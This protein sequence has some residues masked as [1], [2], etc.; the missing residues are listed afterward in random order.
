MASINLI[1]QSTKSPAVIYIRLR[2]GRNIDLKAKTNYHIDPLNW[3]QSEQRP[4]KKVRKDIDFANLDTDLKDLK[5]GLLKEYNNSK[6]VKIID[7]QWIN[8]YIN[9]PKEAEI[10]SNKLIDYIDIFI[11][12]RKQDVKASTITKCNGIK[13]LL[14]RYQEYT[15]TVLHIRDIDVKFKMD[16]EKYCL[17][18][19][20]APNTIARNIRFIKTFCRHAKSNGVETNYQLDNIK[21]KYHKVD[22]IYLT[23][24]EISKIVNIPIKDLSEGIENARDWL[25][26]SCYCGQRV[27]DFLRFDKSMIRYE[28]NKQGVLTPLI[29]FTQMKTDKLM[30]IPLSPKVIEIMKKYDG[31]FPK[32]IS[33]QKYNIH[34]KKVCEIAKINE[35]II[36]TKFDHEIKIKVEKEYQKW[37]LV[38]SH[39]GRRS[40]ASNNYG[41]V[42]TSFLMYMT[43]HTTEAMFLTYIGKSNKDIAM[44]LANYF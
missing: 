15:K 21:A 11:A 34:I 13:H 17:S 41:T 7:N 10:Y 29:E 3:D 37:E 33:D 2:D 9:P 14:M 1:V 18:K 25:L 8:D 43:G 26:I 32:K 24:E 19:K 31:N 38:S 36:G 6:G 27:S 22:N 39:I 20:Y 28:K 23:E 42:P 12:F 16:F 5:N 4:I 40:F 44:E 35:L 30:T